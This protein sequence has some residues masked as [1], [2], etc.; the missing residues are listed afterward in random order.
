MEKF[1]TDERTGLMN[2]LPLR[3]MRRRCRRLHRMALLL[4]SLFREKI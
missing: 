4:Y 2:C 1:V 3:T